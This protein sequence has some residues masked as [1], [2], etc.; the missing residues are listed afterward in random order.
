[1]D[2][3]LRIILVVVGAL[4]II[5]LI[6]ADRI[7]R[8][9][10]H[11]QPY[12]RFSESEDLDLPSMS[13]THEAPAHDD[14]GDMH[15]DDVVDLSSI[16][17]PEE[18]DVSE[19]VVISNSNLETTTSF[20]AEHIELPEPMD[21][22][23]GVIDAVE[24]FDEVDDSVPA[25]DQHDDVVEENE[26]LEEAEEAKGMVL[27]LL[28]LAPKGEK[29]RGS[30]LKMALKE[31]GLSYGKMEIFHQLDGDEALVSVAN[32]LEPGTFDPEEMSTLK[33]PGVVIFS[34]LPSLRA[35]AE[36][37]AAW[38]TAAR[39]LNIALGG[40]LCSINRMPLE[41][42]YFE[43]L[44]QQAEQFDAVDQDLA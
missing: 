7:K 30:Q 33:T 3:D 13:A 18:F 19:A 17:Q 42:G 25:P 15:I 16:A 43:Q 28:L 1:M 22:S 11:N 5:G 21:E 29:F 26:D 32:V 36:V 4:V 41:D 2:M 8:K 35:G 34:Q 9:K 14:L 40:R 12:R 27:S 23:V 38:H 37:F 44:Q 31:S 20:E 39:K 6:I 10:S 24:E